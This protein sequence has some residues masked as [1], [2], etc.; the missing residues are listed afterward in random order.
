MS[1]RK[2]ENGE[3][4][5]SNLERSR[6]DLAPRVGETKVSY[7]LIVA[8][9]PGQIREALDSIDSFLY[10][11]PPNCRI[12]AI[13]DHTEDGT[14]AALLALKDPRLVILRNTRPE[15]YAGLVHTIADGLAAALHSAELR[16][17]LKTD[18]DA[19]MIGCGLFHD[20]QEFALANP[21]V[22][23]FGRY[24]MNYD[25]SPKSFGNMPDVFRW[26]IHWKRRFVPGTRDFRN[27]VRRAT[28]NGWTLGENVF[29]GGYFLSSE[30]AR[31]I[32]SAG[33]L[34]TRS[35]LRSCSAVIAEDAYMTMA[36]YAVGMRP[37]QFAHPKGPMGLA[38][39]G[40]PAPPAVLRREGMKLIHTVDKGKF[41]PRCTESPHNPREF[42]S[43]LRAY[44]DF[45]VTEDPSNSFKAVA[46]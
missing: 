45:Q 35:I 41:T 44:G 30:C 6:L 25:G 42:F 39:D 31:S 34:H 20:A 21:T 29:G 43:K 13:D 2:I 36:A 32:A 12:I 23:I 22:G 19:L 46:T 27:V 17:V 10:F 1:Q 3:V 37:G 18:T 11:C 4:L 24:A 38:Y 8:V 5:A 28:S 9:G 26:Q 40:L 33:L 14:Y 7:A 15:K 16:L